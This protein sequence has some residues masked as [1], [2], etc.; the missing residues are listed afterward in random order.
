MRIVYDASARAH[1]SA[2]SLNDCLNAGPPLQNKL[3]DVLVLQRCYPVAVTGDLKKAFLQLQIRELDRDALRFHWRQ[4]KHS[5]LETLRFTRA[6][7]GLT[8]SPFLLVGVLECH[9]GAWEPKMP[10]LVAELRKNLYVDDLLSGGVTVKQA[11][12]H[13]EQAIE[14]FDDA[15]FTLHKWH[16]NVL[17][18]EGETENKDTDLS[19]AKQQLQQPGE[20][21]TSLLGL[22]WDKGKDE[23]KIKFPT[24]EVQPTKRG[25]LSKLAKV[26]DPLGL[27]LPMALEGKV[28]FRDVC[29]QKQAWDAK[30]VGPLLRRWQKW[31]QSLPMEVSLPRSITS[32]QEPLLDVELHSFGDRSKLG[33]GAA[34]YA[35]VTQESGTT[36]R[37]VAAKVSLAKALPSIPRL[38]LVAGDMATNLLTNV[39]NT[40]EGLPISNV[41][42]R[43][44]STVALH[45]IRGSGEFKQFCP[46]Q[47]NEDQS[48]VRCGVETC[49]L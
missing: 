35:V 2:P 28:S 38:E 6:L 4:N 41:Y 26:Y 22:G 39:R 15:G 18:L 46:E 20:T 11:Q 5:L 48:A 25:V 16:S 17:I 31:E 34:V 45:W 3:W 36:Q 13:K 33:V 37:L 10:E 32:F 44:D 27:V 42:G 14:I 49:Q 9:L 12:H 47:G 43:L 1:P 40:L 23:L 7:F 19:F 29:D 24:E 8:C 30:L 21:K